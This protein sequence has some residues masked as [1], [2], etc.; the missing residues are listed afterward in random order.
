LEQADMKRANMKTSNAVMIQLGL[1]V[2]AL[3]LLPIAGLVLGQSQHV[4][5]VLGI[6]LASGAMLLFFVA[7]FNLVYG[8]SKRHK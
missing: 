2:V 3:I 8:E 6:G 1:I 7:L 4:H 5:L